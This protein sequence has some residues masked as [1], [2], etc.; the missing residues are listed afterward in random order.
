MTKTK[1]SQKSLQNLQEPIF[2]VVVS[3]K[4]NGE[5]SLSHGWRVT[6]DGQKM[7]MWIGDIRPILGGLRSEQCRWEGSENK[8]LQAEAAAVCVYAKSFSFDHINFRWHSLW[9]GNWKKGQ[10]CRRR[11]SFVMT[12]VV[13]MAVS[14]DKRCCFWEREKK[15]IR[16]SWMGLLTWFWRVGAIIVRWLCG[17]ALFQCLDVILVSWRNLG[18]IL[19]VLYAGA[20]PVPWRKFGAHELVLDPWRFFGA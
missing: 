7:R 12:I 14:R 2:D 13:K 17:L 5:S 6:L 1:K 10:G 3:R 8:C 20:F 11:D 4:G 19:Q 15:D 16:I 18:A 9:K